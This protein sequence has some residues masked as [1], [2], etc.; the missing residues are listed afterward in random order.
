M[1][2]AYSQAAGAWASGPER[3]YGPLAVELVGRCPGGV[4]GRRVLDVGAGTGA[5]SRAASDAGAVAVIAVDVAR[6]ML[7]HR[8]DRRPPAAVG[9]ARRL[10]FAPA[11]FDVVVAAFSLNHVS[12][13]EVALAEARRVLRGDGALVV[14]AYVPT[15]EHPVK[16]AVEAACAARGWTSEPWYGALRRDAMPALATP[17]RALDAA[18]RA[19]L[20]GAEAAVVRR[21]IEGLDGEALIAW[22]LGMAPLA[23]FV[24]GLAGPERAAVAADA[25][26]RLG[27]STG[28]LVRSF[29]VLS[30]S[31][32]G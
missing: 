31:G 32:T 8:A 5:A 23:G 1:Q 2:A 16:A 22:R 17:E 9:D 20:D 4:A 29:V 6:G 15:V 21:S 11:S 14:S 19:G 26:A 24:A 10:P 3:I 12:D 7:A 18:A 25:R 30:W 28:P 27:R 13:P